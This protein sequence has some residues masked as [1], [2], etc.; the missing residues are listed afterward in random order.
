MPR[1]CSFASRRPSRC[2]SLALAYVLLTTL[3]APP[4]VGL[5]SA[6]AGSKRLPSTGGTKAQTVSVVRRRG[7]ELL[8]R[9]RGNV[10]EQARSAAVEARGGHRLRR[11]RGESG[12]EKIELVA[13]LDLDAAAALLGADPAVEFVEPNFLVSGDQT[14]PSDPRFGEQWALRN[15]GQSGGVAGSDIQAEAAWQATTGNLRR[16]SRS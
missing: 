16:S 2:L 4:G 7:N 9:F 15:V 14:A 13:G 11:L 6:S 1:V 10:S 5:L 3:C 12:L 8:V